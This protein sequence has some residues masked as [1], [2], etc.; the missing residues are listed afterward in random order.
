MASQWTCGPVVRDEALCLQR[1]ILACVL[2]FG[3]LL[4]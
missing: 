1:V 3:S 4:D 2:L